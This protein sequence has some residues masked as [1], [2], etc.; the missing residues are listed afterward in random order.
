MLEHLPDNTKMTTRE[1][2]FSQPSDYSNVVLTVY[3]T[4]R[5]LLPP[6][7]RHLRPPNRAHVPA[8]ACGLMG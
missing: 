1:Y 4:I 3:S 2:L 5:A 7:R 8:P 6:H